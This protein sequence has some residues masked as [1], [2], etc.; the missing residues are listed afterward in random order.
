MH[1]IGGS[2]DLMSDVFVFQKDLKN[3]IRQDLQD[4][5]DQFV[6]AFRMKAD[7]LQRLRRKITAGSLFAAKRLTPSGSL[8]ESRKTSCQ[9]C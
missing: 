1:F 3:L 7:T 8:P 5:Q 4:L 6:S 2:D 9:S